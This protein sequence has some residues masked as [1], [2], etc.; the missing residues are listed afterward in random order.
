MWI[1]FIFGG[2]IL[3]GRFEVCLKKK[4]EIYVIKGLNL[5]KISLG[6]FIFFENKILMIELK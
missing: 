5:E 4:S 6:F 3:E 2:C 1:L